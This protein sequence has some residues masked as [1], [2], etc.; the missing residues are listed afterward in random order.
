ME[1]TIHTKDIVLIYIE[2]YINIP[3]G[4]KGC[5][6]VDGEIMAGSAGFVCEL[7]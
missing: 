2:L 3:R 6:F 4:G 5:S 1:R 7:N